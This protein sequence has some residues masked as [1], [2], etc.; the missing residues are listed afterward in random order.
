VISTEKLWPFLLRFPISCFGICLGV[1]SQSILWKTLAATPSMEFLHVPEIINLVLW[2]LGLVTLIII[3]VVYTLKCIFYFEAVR[4]EYYNPVRVNFFFA[5]WIACMFLAL[6]VPP[7]IAKSIHP[8]IWCVFMSPVLCLELKI[9]GQWM[10]GGRR[11]LSEIAN[12][13][14]YLSIVGNFVGALLGAATGWKEGAPFYLCCG[15]GPL[16]G[17]FCDTLPEITHN[18]NSP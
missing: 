6:G 9:Y 3:F 7:H 17:A 2:C 1:G 11:R 10:L 13:S 4:I 14:N 18:R 8:A 5:P 15:V 12:P 16:H